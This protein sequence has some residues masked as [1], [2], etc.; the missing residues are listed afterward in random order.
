M[1]PCCGLW[2]QPSVDHC[3]TVRWILKW[4]YRQIICR[5]FCQSRWWQWLGHGTQFCHRRMI[6]SWSLFFVNKTSIPA[7]QRHEGY[8]LVVVHNKYCTHRFLLFSTRRYTPSTVVYCRRSDCG[9]LRYSLVT[10]Y[11]IMRN[12]RNKT[13]RSQDQ[14]LDWLTGD[15]QSDFWLRDKDASN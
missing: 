13:P 8:L 6:L 14:F 2:S 5:Q 9:S 12:H 15:T 7:R 10:S 1:S 3:R 11:I 4:W